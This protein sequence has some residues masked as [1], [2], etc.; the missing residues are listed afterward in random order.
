MTSRRTHVCWS[1]LL[2][3][4]GKCQIWAD[5]AEDTSSLSFSFMLCDTFIIKRVVR[6]IQDLTY[7]HFDIER[8]HHFLPADWSRGSDSFFFYFGAK[9]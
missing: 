4:K 7:L 6:V 1:K 5:W 2:L 8:A 3:S 9:V